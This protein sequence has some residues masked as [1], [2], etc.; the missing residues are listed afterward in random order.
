MFA[1]D[2]LDLRDRA[3]TAS[4]AGRIPGS[5]ASAG[6]DQL[7][8]S[9]LADPAN[10][11]PVHATTWRDVPA[12]TPRWSALSLP[13]TSGATDSI[14]AT[15]YRRAAAR[16]TLI[17]TAVAGGRTRPLRNGQAIPGTAQNPPQHR[18]RS[19]AY[20]DT[21]LVRWLAD[22]ASLIP[23]RGREH[24]NGPAGTVL[25]TT[26]ARLIYPGDRSSHIFAGAA[27]QRRR[28]LVIAAAAT[29]RVHLADGETDP[30]LGRLDCAGFTVYR[31]EPDSEIALG[32][33]L[34]HAARRAL[35]NAATPATQP[36]T[37][38]G[39]TNS[40]A[41]SNSPPPGA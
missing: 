17:E 11:V 19:T 3:A 18:N 25:W 14:F 32:L 38:P 39:R 16:R 30:A 36:P 5:Q 37:P 21:G 26:L 2:L 35:A 4:D 28:D 9:W 6:Y 1:G 13:I 31:Q 22:P 29:G 33:R 12:G 7:V 15:G 24:R 8:A 27:G 23:I 40:A 20:L 41:S 10:L 34:K